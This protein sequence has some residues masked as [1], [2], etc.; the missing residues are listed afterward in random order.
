M[1]LVSANRLSDGAVIYL[2]RDGGY[3]ERLCDAARFDTAA[4]ED[5][6]R[7]LSAAIDVV[8]V[9]GVEVDG[10]APV[11]RAALRETIRSAG[12]TTRRDLGKQAEVRNVSL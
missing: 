11:G 1:K 5:E 7:R 8:E 10:D 4:A 3:V 6:I 9:C 12:P 2:G